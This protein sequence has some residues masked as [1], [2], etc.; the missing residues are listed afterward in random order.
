MCKKRIEKAA[1]IKGVKMA[2][3]DK[4]GQTI[5][6]VYKTK[7]VSEDDIHKAIAKVGH[8]TERFKGDDTKY[9]KLPECCRYRDGVDIH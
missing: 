7:N 5:K 3:W 6:V 4:V 2:T 1:L 8:D 9:D